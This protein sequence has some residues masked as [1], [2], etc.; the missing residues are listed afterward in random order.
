MHLKLK[1]RQYP[2]IQPNY[3]ISRCTTLHNNII[4]IFDTVPMQK[5]NLAHEK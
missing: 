3:I 2:A 1:L 5:G 4:I